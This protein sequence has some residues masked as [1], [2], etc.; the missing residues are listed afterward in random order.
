MLGG[1][2]ADIETRKQ[3]A[4]I[5]Y[6]IFI[7][8]SLYT[9]Y[10]QFLLCCHFIFYFLSWNF[11]SSLKEN[12]SFNILNKMP[13]KLLCINISRGLQWHSREVR[14]GVEVDTLLFRFGNKNKAFFQSDFSLL[15]GT[16]PQDNKEMSS[17]TVKEN[18]IG[19]VV[20]SHAT[21]I[22]R[23]TSDYVRII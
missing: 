1:R 2:S 12:K 4:I 18:H 9:V 23:Q 22:D 21:Y 3:N 13:V 10:L 6:F 20:S 14:K 17:F 11:T 16:L 7:V 8:Y 5:K 15:G 19:S